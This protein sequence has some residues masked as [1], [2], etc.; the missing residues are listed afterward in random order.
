[1]LLV[2]KTKANVARMKGKKKKNR[3]SDEKYLW[4]LVLPGVILTLIFSYLPMAGIYMAFSNYVPTQAGFLHDLVNAPFVGF[5][6]FSYFFKND[7]SMIMRNTLAMSV[8]SLI[9]SFP[10]PIAIAVFLNEVRIKWLKKSI[11]TVSYLP[12][13]ISWVIAA[14]IILTFCSGDGIINQVLINMHIISKPILFFQQSQYFWW[15]LALAN[16]WKGIGYNAIIYLAAI[17]GINPELYE[18]ADVDGAS[19]WQKIVS[20]TLPS[21]KPTI[22]I[23]FILAIGGIL[24]TGFEQILLL[25]NDS[26]LNVSDVLDTYSYRYGLQNGMYSYG[27]AVGLFKSVVSFILVLGANRL[28]RHYNDGSALF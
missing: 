20:I 2:D 17:S 5:Q 6:W 23:L 13:F 18:A 19:R 25:Q 26:I 3:F 12:Y 15:I 22:I 1:M 4:L 16:T 14:N 21:L 11:Q 8:L 24:N 7:F 10:V 28:T 27:A 9:F